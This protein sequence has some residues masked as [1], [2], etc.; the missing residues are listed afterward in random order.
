MIYTSRQHPFFEHYQHRRYK[1]KFEQDQPSQL[2]N[3]QY[4]SL[5]RTLDTLSTHIP[6]HLLNLLRLTM[7]SIHIQYP[8]LL[9]FM[10][11]I[12]YLYILFFIHLFL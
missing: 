12:L 1:I 7:I 10:V 8:D 11:L 5:D 2:F 4:T 3:M 6:Y 9:K